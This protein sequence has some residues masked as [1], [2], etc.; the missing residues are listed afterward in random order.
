MSFSI[1]KLVD[2]QWRL[3][4]AMKSNSSKNLMTPYVSGK[5]ERIKID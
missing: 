4:I 2:F 3:G 1:G 5:V